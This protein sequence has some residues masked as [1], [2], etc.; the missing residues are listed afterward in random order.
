[1]AASRIGIVLAQLGT[2]DAPTPSALRRYLR[3]FLGDQ[4][5]VEQN[6]LTWWFVLNFLILP[7]RPARSAAM[8]KHIWTAKGSP[9]L[10]YTQAQAEGLQR[11]LGA[12]VQVEVGMRYGNPSIA[13]AL[14]RLQG[15]EKVLIFPMFPQYTAATTGSVHDA[16]FDHYRRTRVIP[17]LRVV[18]PYYQHPA[19]IDALAAIARQE[20]AKLTWKP[21]RILLTYHGIPQRFV[22]N[23]DVYAQHCVATTA[24]IRQA[25][26]QNVQQSYQSRF[27]REEWLKP[28]T[29]ET[30]AQL[31]KEGVT[32]LAV[33]CPGFTADCLETIDEMGHEGRE[34]FMGGGGKDF[35]LIPCPNDS[36]VWLDAMARIAREEL[37]GWLD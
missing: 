19:Y 23:G 18:A 27:G 36:P 20:L 25:L 29:D 1:M 7:R 35:A 13:A 22:D 3:Q 15:C 31:P 5:V 32:Q 9:L 4:R 10:L 28:Y 24:A 34:A 26:N 8:Y 12:Q 21:Q 14:E 37:A 33:M 2:P 11:L 30:L 16:V 17:A 6:P